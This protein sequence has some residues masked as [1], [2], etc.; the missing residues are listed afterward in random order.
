MFYSIHHKSA[1]EHG[2]ESS[3][4]SQDKASQPEDIA[5]EDLGVANILDIH[6]EQHTK[7]PREALHHLTEHKYR[8]TSM[9]ARLKA[10]RLAM[11]K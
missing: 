2:E 7:Q 11:G 8:N 9:V 4:P 10:D 3:Q 1:N 5:P 6:L